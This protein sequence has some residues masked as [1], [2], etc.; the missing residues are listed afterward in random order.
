MPLSLQSE[1]LQSPVDNIQYYL[2][3]PGNTPPG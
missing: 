1:W 3:M 2:A